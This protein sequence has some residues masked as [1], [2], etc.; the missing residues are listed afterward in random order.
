MPREL[1]SSRF[2]R[3]GSYAVIEVRR[4]KRRVGRKR[5]F[6]SASIRSSSRRLLRSQFFIHAST[7]A[8]SFRIAAVR[9]RARD[10]HVGPI[11]TPM[12][13]RMFLGSVELASPGSIEAHAGLSGRGLPS[14]W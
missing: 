6:P 12:R 10:H 14:T 13:R 1:R 4:C 5:R 7:S 2:L 3:H 11:R 9:R 8:I